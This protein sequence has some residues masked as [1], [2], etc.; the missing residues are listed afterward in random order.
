MVDNTT[1]CVPIAP[2]FLQPAGPIVDPAELVGL[3][4]IEGML[5][6]RLRDA[7]TGVPP[8]A[9]KGR[10]SERNSDLVHELPDDP[11]LDPEATARLG[12]PQ[13]TVVGNESLRGDGIQQ[14]LTFDPVLRLGGETRAKFE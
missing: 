7:L 2:T 1:A 5:T 13:A 6:K 8:R 9:E 4:S 10:L 14:P 12:D 11:V 3:K